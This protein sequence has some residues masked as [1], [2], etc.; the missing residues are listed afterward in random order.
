MGHPLT[1]RKGRT[2][3][4]FR[5]SRRNNNI[6]SWRIQRKVAASVI[7]MHAAGHNDLAPLTNIQGGQIASDWG[8]SNVYFFCTDDKAAFLFNQMSNEGT[9]GNLKVHQSRPELFESQFPVETLVTGSWY[10]N[11]PSH[12]SCFE[13]GHG[14]M[15][16]NF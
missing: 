7:S 2:H 3:I 6:R 5:D 4:L 11:W 14:L 1:P 15:R 8:H 16:T 9:S 13:G 12:V 10:R